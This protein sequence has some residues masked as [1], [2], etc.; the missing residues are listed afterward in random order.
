MPDVKVFVKGGITAD[1]NIHQPL[2]SYISIHLD[3]SECFVGGEHIDLMV[4]PIVDGEME[5]TTQQPRLYSGSDVI[6]EVSGYA[7]ASRM[8]NIEDRLKAI[9]IEVKKALGLGDAHR[10]SIT[11]FVV[12]ENYWAAV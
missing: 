1:G 3:C 9:A 12:E 6:I 7:Y 5:Y 8:A 10:A 11:Y 2:R 4:I